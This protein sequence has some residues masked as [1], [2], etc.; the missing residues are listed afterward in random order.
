VRQLVTSGPYARIRHPL[1][2]GEITHIL[3][4]AILSGT[5]VGLYSFVFAVVMQVARANDHGAS[6]ATPDDEMSPRP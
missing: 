3:G 1:Y 6:R 5:P 2:L 4:M